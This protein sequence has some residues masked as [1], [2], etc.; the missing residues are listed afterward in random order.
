MRNSFLA[1]CARLAWVDELGDDEVAEGDEEQQ[2][3]EQPARLVV[4]QDADEEQVGVAQ[5]TLVAEE[6]E[7]SEDDG[8]ERPELELR[9]E[10]RAFGVEGEHRLQVFPQYRQVFFNFHWFPSNL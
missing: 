9:E 5:Q 7:H 8:E 10:Q 6:R 2:A 4:E 1:H 3:E